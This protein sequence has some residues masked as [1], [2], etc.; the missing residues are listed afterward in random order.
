MRHWVEGLS[1]P[2]RDLQCVGV[3]G[4][5]VGGWHHEPDAYTW[6]S[7]HH[8]QIVAIDVMARGSEMLE[9]RVQNLGRVPPRA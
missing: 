2:I 4:G 3:F 5:I 7:G 9:E 6:G 1:R 8:I